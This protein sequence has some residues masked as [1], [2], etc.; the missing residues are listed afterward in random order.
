MSVFGTIPHELHRKRRASLNNFFSKASIRQ[1]EPTV[2]DVVGQLLNRMDICGRSG[3][4]LSLNVVFKAVTS[5]IITRYAFGKSTNYVTREDYNRAYFETF[6]NLFELVHWFFQIG[7]LNSLL[8]S[9][10]TAISIRLMPGLAS[11]FKLRL[12]NLATPTLTNEF[13]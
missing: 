9:L 1:L 4:I 11:L 12:V 2:R 10:P 3:E 13:D 5:D 6:E 8:S 7:W